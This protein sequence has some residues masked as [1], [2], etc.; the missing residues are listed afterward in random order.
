MAEQW[1]ANTSVTD[2]EFAGGEAKQK[3]KSGYLWQRRSRGS[4]Q[5]GGSKKHS[6]W[7]IWGLGE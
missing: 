4:D 7:I 1:L 5:V 2:H 3:E 6:N